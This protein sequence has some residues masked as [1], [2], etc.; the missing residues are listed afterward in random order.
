MDQVCVI[1]TFFSFLN[2]L[3]D[4]EY[5]RLTC[6]LKKGWGITKI[7]LVTFKKLDIKDSKENWYLS[8]DLFILAMAQCQQQRIQFFLKNVLP[9]YTGKL[10]QHE[11]YSI[12]WD[13]NGCLSMPSYKCI[14][15]GADSKPV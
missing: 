14:I 15:D 12:C 8:I 3:A 5:N 10:Q 6:Y 1:N 4:K 9:I 13:I 2:T 11:S 7:F